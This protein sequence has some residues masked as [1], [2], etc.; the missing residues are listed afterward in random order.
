V[1]FDLADGARVEHWY[2]T[3]K[4]GDVGVSRNGAEADAV[5]RTAK[6]LFEGMTSGRVNAMAALR[7]AL[8]PWGNLAL[9]VSFQRLLPGPAVSRAKAGPGGGEGSMR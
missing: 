9:V 6:V 7:G 8:V 4:N 3:I 1:R 5:V 2:L